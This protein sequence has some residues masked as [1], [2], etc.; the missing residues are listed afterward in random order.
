MDR[1]ERRNGF[2]FSVPGAESGQRLA[3]SVAQV[4]GSVVGGQAFRRGPEVEGVAAA[5]ALE[6]VEQVAVEVGGEAAA[7][8]GRGAVQGTRAASLGA[9]GVGGPEAEQ[10]QDVGHGCGGADGGEVDGGLRRDCGLR[11]RML[12]LALPQE[13]AAFA[14][15]G[16]LA[17]ACVEYLLVASVEL[18]LGGDVADGAV[19]ADGVVVEDVLVDDASGVVEGQG[20]SKPD[21]LA[22]DGSV[23][24][25][26]LAVGL[27][28]VGRGGDVGH[29]GDA[30]ELLEIL[31]DELGSVVGDDPRGCGGVLLAG[32]LQVAG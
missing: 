8:G 12:S 26:E 27:G 16:Q 9:S 2:L 17:V 21:A 32:A 13:T 7:G 31:G 23:P 14:G 1:V 22:L 20:H 29:T 28:V 5:V 4:D 25:F 15:L 30:D 24:A 18:V 11:R 3:Q 10:S 6:A 19:Q